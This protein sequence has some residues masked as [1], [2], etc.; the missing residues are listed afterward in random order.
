MDPPCTI[1]GGDFCTQG[2]ACT[3][4]PVC[5]DSVEPMSWGAIKEMF[6]DER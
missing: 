3:D 5:K 2:F 1:A 6:L 4:G